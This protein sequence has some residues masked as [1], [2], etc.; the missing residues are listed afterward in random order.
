[1]K[2]GDSISRSPISLSS[3]PSADVLPVTAG[4]SGSHGFVVIELASR[5]RP[6]AVTLE[7][8]PKSISPMGKIDS[9]PG[10]LQSTGWTMTLKKRALFGTLYLRS[11]WRPSSDLPAKG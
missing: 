1:M 6:T 11:E 7:H 3:L 5:I 8:I 9:A 10:T 2:K 4:R